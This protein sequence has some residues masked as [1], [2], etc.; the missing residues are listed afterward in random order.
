MRRENIVAVGFVGTLL[1]IPSAYPN[2]GV[3]R[4]H[5]GPDEG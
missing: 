4:A 3:G 5:Q 1:L 2:A